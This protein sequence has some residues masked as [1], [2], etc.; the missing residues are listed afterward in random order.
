VLKENIKLKLIVFERTILRR[1]F[2][3]TKDRDGPWRIKSNEELNRQIGNKNIINHIKAQRLAWFRQ[4]HRMPDDRKVK[5][6]YEWKPMSTRSLGRTQKR[7]EDDV[8]NNVKNMRI[9]S[10]KDCIRNR[11]KRN[12]VVEKAKTSLKL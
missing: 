3:P 6:V 9:N 1:I 2:R 12:E 5:K 7:W 8:K 11:P 4:V 10:W